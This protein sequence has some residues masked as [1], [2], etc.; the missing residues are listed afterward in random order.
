[1]GQYVHALTLGGVLALAGAGCG[2]GG[3]PPAPA[4]ARA[5]PADAAPIADAAPAPPERRVMERVPTWSGERLWGVGL[6][7]DCTAVKAYDSFVAF[8]CRLAVDALT[9]FF[10]FRFPAGRLERTGDARR[11]EP[12]TDRSGYARVHPF[13]RR[14]GVEARLVVFRGAGDLDDPMA[15]TLFA[16]LRPKAGAAQRTLTEEDFE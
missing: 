4:A 8:D 5:E 7:R 12:G 13:S 11:F 16:R 3:P 2:E 15:R 1:M 9:A 6:P 10:T 14:G